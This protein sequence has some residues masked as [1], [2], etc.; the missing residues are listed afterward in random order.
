MENPLKIG[1]LA[2]EVDVPISTLRYYERSGLLAPARRTESN[3]RLYSSESVERVRF[4]RS[5]QA[6]GFTIA[7][8]RALL[9]LRDGDT[10][11]CAEVRP[12]IEHRLSQVAER[13]EEFE[14][15]QR[16][17]RAFL[18]ICSRTDNDDDCGAIEQLRP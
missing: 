14:H 13:I 7:D 9:E 6:A 1:D 15:F 17:L 10:T 11:R 2:R 3:Y 4:I 5:A 18:D 8:I 12:V 16:A